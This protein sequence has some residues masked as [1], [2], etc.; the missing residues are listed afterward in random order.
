MGE[1][2]AGD[3]ACLLNTGVEGDR[4][5]LGDE[6]DRFLSGGFRDLSG[7]GGRVGGVRGVAG[8]SNEVRRLPEGS[9]CSKLQIRSGSYA[10]GEEGDEGG[11]ES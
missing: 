1:F 11:G 10:D 6:I 3:A 8:V 2:E 4:T 5:R 9:D 7:S